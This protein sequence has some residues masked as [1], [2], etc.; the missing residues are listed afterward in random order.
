ME[1]GLNEILTMIDKVKS[2]NLALFEYEDADTKLRIKG[3]KPGAARAGQRAYAGGVA[4]YAG[5]QPS[6]ADYAGAQPNE[7][8]EMAA[9]KPEAGKTVDSPMVGTFYAAASEGEEPFVRVGDAVK[10][11]QTIGIVEAMKL[12]NEIESEYTGV[13]EEILVENEQMVEF[14]QPLIRVREV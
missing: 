9:D 7:A 14:G 13:V 6:M 5:A 3:T 2:T 12:M 4:D 8:A 1:F 10:K 11:G